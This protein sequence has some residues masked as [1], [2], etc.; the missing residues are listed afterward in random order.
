M[1]AVA[2]AG[3]ASAQVTI[4]GAMG[5]GIQDSSDMARELSW[6]D[7]SVKFSVSEDLGGGMSVAGSTALAFADHGDA[8]TADGS[9]L[10]VT[11]GFGAVN[12]MTGSSDADNLGVAS[13][14][15][16]TNNVFGGSTT[17]YAAFNY[18]LPMFV[19]GLSVTIRLNQGNA[20][21]VQVTD[22]NEQYRIG[23]TTGPLAVAFN[24][25]K[26][27]SDLKASYDFGM[28]KITAFTDV[29]RAETA[30]ASMKRREFAISVPV[31][32]SVTLAASMASR[33]S[34]T[35]GNGDTKGTEYNA[36]YMMSKR[37]SLSFNYG[38][39]TASDGAAKT[40]NRIKLVHSF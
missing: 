38:S 9:S 15:F 24:T 8:A 17:N 32:S 20:G 30:D 13:L 2:V 34:F 10:T 4:T 7:G 18:T 16:S 23:Y 35:A 31:S 29:K 5:F 12:Y 21:N 14:P 28:A 26:G 36:T 6:T 33:P 1:A 25:T 37:T 39:F 40:A 11:T 19:D 3:A 27:A 22:E